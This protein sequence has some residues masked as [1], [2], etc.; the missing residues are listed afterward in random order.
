MI[1]PNGSKSSKAERDAS[2]AAIIHHIEAYLDQAESDPLFAGV[3]FD[4]LRDGS[5][6][7]L[8]VRVVLCDRIFGEPQRRLSIGD[9]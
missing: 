9:D 2:R 6:K 4:E 3:V 1:Q 8:A 5:N 7:L